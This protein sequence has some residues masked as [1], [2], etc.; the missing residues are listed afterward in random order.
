MGGRS[1]N[2]SHFLLPPGVAIHRRI[3]TTI[4]TM[5]AM[6]TTSQTLA[7]MLDIPMTIRV[8]SGRVPFRLVNK[9]LKIGTMKIII[10]VMITMTAHITMDGY[11][12][13]DRTF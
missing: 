12:M 6:T 8:G 11:A 4:A 9:C 10:A 2:A 1:L 5:T 13:A 3:P 7:T